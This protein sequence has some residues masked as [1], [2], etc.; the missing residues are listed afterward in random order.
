MFEYEY[1]SSSV[2]LNSLKSISQ[3]SIVNWVLLA[4]LGVLTILSILYFIPFLKN[5]FIKLNET[6]KKN[7]NKKMLKRIAF[8]KNIEDAI[9]E[10]VRLSS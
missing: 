6:A 9:A 1:L 2:A 8:Q 7:K 10:E 5:Y 3:Y 4:I